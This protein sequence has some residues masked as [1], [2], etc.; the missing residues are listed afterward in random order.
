MR[1][2][3]K[4]T[5]GLGST[6]CRCASRYSVVPWLWGGR[7]LRFRGGLIQKHQ[8]RVPF[9]LADVFVV[10]FVRWCLVAHVGA[11]SSVDAPH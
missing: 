11:Y 9:Q 3:V 2:P 7:V 6:V 1:R 10:V 5:A 8:I 4:N